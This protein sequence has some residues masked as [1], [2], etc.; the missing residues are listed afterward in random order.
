MP[1]P[2]PRPP[3]QAFRRSHSSPASPAAPHKFAPANPPAPN[4]PRNAAPPTPSHSQ[5]WPPADVSSTHNTNLPKYTPHHA[6]EPQST[7]PPCDPPEPPH[8][9]H[10]SPAS[11]EEPRSHTAQADAKAVEE[12]RPQP[13][14]SH[15]K[16]TTP[17]N[18]SP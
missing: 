3:A 10:S 16:T 15:S 17:A 6:A 13:Q 12:S 9:F 18:S 8:P 4:P 1:P 5:A 14:A 2:H 11:P 7:P